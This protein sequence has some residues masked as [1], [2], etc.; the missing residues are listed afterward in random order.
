MYSK[1][2]SRRATL[3]A[4]KQQEGSEGKEK[5]KERRKQKKEKKDKRERR[6]GHKSKHHKKDK[7]GKSKIDLD[8]F[9]SLES[10]TQK[11]LSM[12]PSVLD[13]SENSANLFRS[14]LITNSEEILTVAKLEEKSRLS[15][16]PSQS[17][18]GQTT[19]SESGSSTSS[20]SSSGGAGGSD[21][22]S[23]ASSSSGTI[24]TE[25]I[26]HGIERRELSRLPTEIAALSTDDGLSKESSQ[27]QSDMLL[28]QDAQ[29]SQVSDWSIDRVLA[30]NTQQEQ[31]PPGSHMQDLE[32]DLASKVN[33][34]TEQNKVVPTSP[35]GPMAPA[36]VSHVDSLQHQSGVVKPPATSPQQQYQGVAHPGMY[37]Q[38]HQQQNQQQQLQRTAYH[39]QHLPHQQQML[40]QQQQQ[41]MHQQQQVSPTQH[42]HQQVSHHH[43]QQQQQQMSPTYP[44]DHMARMGQ[45]V[46]PQQVGARM[47]P[48]M[49]TV[50]QVRCPVM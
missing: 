46:P 19:P 15:S 49:G 2:K 38:Q 48:N 13:R 47:T 17:D 25:P 27:E 1:V 21:G 3:D 41:M 31:Q 33:L 37:Q 11:T 18:K 40:P 8:L 32:Q 16:S 36:K 12:S 39:Q 42:H 35:V 22:E 43:Q 4:K 28:Q 30:T 23:N 14:S 20:S 10:A 34:N 7:K 6:S 44:V 5:S 29:E 26:V 24:I 45:Q 9:G 50:P